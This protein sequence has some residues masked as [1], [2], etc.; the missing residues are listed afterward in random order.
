MI[1]SK[2]IAPDLQAR[3][4]GQTP[5]FDVE[6]ALQQCRRSLEMFA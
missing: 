5:V 6:T 3:Q 2:R 4:K 1:S